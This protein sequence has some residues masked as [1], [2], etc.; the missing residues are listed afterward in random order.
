MPKCKDCIHFLVCAN[1]HGQ[2]TA[3]TEIT[4]I[5]GEQC[6]Y[7]F[8]KCNPN[9]DLIKIRFTTNKDSSTDG[10]FHTR[11]RVEKFLKGNGYVK[12]SVRYCNNSDSTF[13]GCD[14]LFKRR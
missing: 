13:A 10:Y 9:I 7:F 5:D 11:R 8:D 3:D 1:L 4:N 14:V 2:V 6:Y 12:D